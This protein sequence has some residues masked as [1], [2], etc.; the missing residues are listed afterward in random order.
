MSAPSASNRKEVM[1][2]ANSKNTRAQKINTTKTAGRRVSDSDMA[3]MVSKA[4]KTLK[5]FPVKEVKIPLLDRKND[6]VEVCYNG[7]NMIVKRGVN[8]KLP[9]PIVR[10]LEHSGVL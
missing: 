5:E 2:M 10:I 3:G 4:A 6:V 7:Y 8:V 9:M 1:V